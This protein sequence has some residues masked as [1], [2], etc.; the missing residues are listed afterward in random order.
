MK[1]FVSNKKVCTRIISFTFCL[2]ISISIMANDCDSIMNILRNPAT[3]YEKKMEIADDICLLSPEDQFIL[4][5]FLKK[6]SKLKQDKE[7]N[8]KIYSYI[9]HAQLFIGQLDLC[10]FYLDLASLP[11]NRIE[12][13]DI[14]GIYNHVSGDYYNMQHNY[15][16]AHEYYYKAI[17]YFQTSKTK[18]N[19]RRSILIFHSIA[20][21]YI[22][23]GDTSSLKVVLDRMYEEVKAVNDDKS[24][25]IY[26]GLLSYYYGIKYEQQK[27]VSDLDSAIICD[28][29]VVRIYE[30]QQS[31]HNIHQEE[32][33]YRYISL[34]NNKLRKNNPDYPEINSWAKKA[35]ELSNPIDTAMLVNCLWVEGLSLYKMKEVRLAEQ[36]LL[37]LAQ[38]MDSWGVSENLEKYSGLCE[39]LSDIYTS[40][41]DY[42]KALMYEKKKSECNLNIYNTEKFK[43]IKEL[44]TKYETEKKEQEIKT[45]KKINIFIALIGLLLGVAS[46]FIIHWQRANRKLLRK[47]LEI[48]EQEKSRIENRLAEQEKQLQEA[49][50]KERKI[51]KEIQEKEQSFNDAKLKGLSDLIEARQEIEILKN[52]KKDLQ[53]MI[54]DVEADI[55]TREGER[56]EIIVYLHD[57]ISKKIKE[58]RREK[59]LNTISK[60][61]SK[62]ILLLKD[63]GLSPMQIEYSILIASGLNPKEL[64]FVFSVVYQTARKNRGKIREVLKIDSLENLDAYLVRLLIPFDKKP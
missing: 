50:V 44:Q 47:Q 18:R 49:K 14:L 20:F 46:F 32:V 56:N 15:K 53:S 43:A 61:D 63:K 35:Y 3:S 13:T 26:Y 22:Q 36:K 8:T 38:I 39:F 54:S 40:Y 24:E 10:K 16:K 52:Q 28:E 51:S 62:G 45:Q 11:I 48:A 31:N 17:D 30:S 55:S 59:M 19:T 41:G 34:A 60:I 5:S 37:N 12:N 23:E 42:E 57:I 27:R 6:E 21:P 29:K 25:S 7:N 64:A 2:Y 58:P 1:A 4:F 9:A 33:A